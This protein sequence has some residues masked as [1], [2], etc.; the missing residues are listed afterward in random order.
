MYFT[1]LLSYLYTIWIDI[2]N[3]LLKS[4]TNLMNSTRNIKMI[5]RIVMCD[6]IVIVKIV[7]E[8][9]DVAKKKINNMEQSVR[10]SNS[11]IIW[12][13]YL[14]Y[15][16]W[17]TMSDE[18]FIFANDITNPLIKFTK[19]DMTIIVFLTHSKFSSMIFTTSA[20]K[21]IACSIY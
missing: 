6:S 12:N 18:W 9:I 16:I 5:V 19:L 4:K 21:I 11:I 1:I 10:F 2:M 7:N 13:T 14:V 3:G 17:Y 20:M 8:L 15:M